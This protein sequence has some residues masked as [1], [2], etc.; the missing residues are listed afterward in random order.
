MYMWL[1]HLMLAPF[2]LSTI[3]TNTTLD[4]PHELG[5]LIQGLPKVA[6]DVLLTAFPSISSP[7]K[8][9][10][11][12]V[13]LVVRL[14]LR[15]D[16]QL[17]KLPQK[18]A[19]HAVQFLLSAND[20]GQTVYHDLGHL[21]LLYALVNLGSDSEVSLFL[22]PV[23]EA[24]ST[25]VT[26]SQTN[27]AATR[28][29]APARKMLIKVMRAC[30]THAIRLAEGSHGPNPDSINSMLEDSVQYYLDALGDKD[31]PVRM[32]A[33]KALSIIAL[34]LDVSM[35]AEIVEAVLG[36]LSENVLVE[37]LQTGQIMAKTDMSTA[38]GR[39]MKRNV[40]AVDALKWHGLMLTL[41]HLLFRR[42]RPPHQL[43]DILEAL[44]LGLE[45]EQ[46]SNVGTS[47]GIGVRDAACFG[48]WALARKYSTHELIAV[49]AD[50]ISGAF[51][52]SN[53]TPQS[54]LQVIATRLVLSSCLDPS[55]N[56]RRGSS[57]ALQE[58]I[59]RHPDTIV[60][61]IPVVQ[62]VDYLAVARRSRAVTEVAVMVSAL[63]PCYHDALLNA[64]LDWR[65]ARAADADSRRWAAIAVEEL[66]GSAPATKRAE[67]LEK[68]LSDL[69]ALKV[70]N[71][72]VTAA[73]RHGLLLCAA[74][75]LTS[76][77][78][79]EHAPSGKVLAVIHDVDVEALSGNLTGRTT[80]DLELVMEGL[81][82]F[83]AAMVIAIADTDKDFEPLSMRFWNILNHSLLASEK[84]S[85]VQACIAAAE[86]LFNRL[87]YKQKQTLTLQ[88]LDEKKQKPSETLCHGRL[89]MLATLHPHMSFDAKLQERVEELLTGTVSGS[90]RIEI[91]VNAMQSLRV[92]LS[93]SPE[94][95]LEIQSL[96][97]EAF[98][99]GLSDYT[100]DQRGD[101]GSLLRLKGIE[102]VDAYQKLVRMRQ[103][104]DVVEDPLLPH[105]VRL[106]IERLSKVRHRAW[107]CLMESWG[108]V[109]DGVTLT[110]NFKYLVD[111]SS[112]AYF[113][114]VV[115]L[116]RVEK[117]QG[118]VLR[119]LSS[120][121]GGGTE[122]ICRACSVA[123]LGWIM[124]MEQGERDRTTRSITISVCKYLEGLKEGEDK[125]VVPGLTFTTFL[126]EQ[127]LLSNQV[128]EGSD[129][130]S[131][132]VWTSVSKLHVQNVSM[133]RLAALI[134][135]YAALVRTS[136]HRN[137]ALD[138]LT[139][140]LLHR[141]PKIRNAAA[142]ALYPM[143]P[144]DR[145]LIC[146]WSAPAASNKATV[147]ELRKGMQLVPAAKA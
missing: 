142:D 136:V 134:Q 118:Q 1:S 119:G 66:C 96:L 128:L 53:R 37:D 85:V 40:N 48:I 49:Q 91:K 58:L 68:T 15:K 125:D 106:A 138:K 52:H 140:Q 75:I 79:H 57:A 30:M 78:E 43:P 11:S 141:Y 29:S 61:G 108:N 38:D 46:R 23:H 51:A 117:L 18:L 36:S 130:G 132:A 99:A 31:S 73:N 34:R 144:L 124:V 44:L 80:T 71:L 135:F 116:L 67:M 14:A 9:R 21:S 107:R 111:L 100:N 17:L 115:S 55:G 82:K 7:S 2:E 147:L 121:I 42:S 39:R 94:R 86:K 41:G 62:I 63:D 131:V 81:G 89:S 95:C 145:L 13:L 69:Q 27:H 20:S 35:S 6:Q 70:T 114:Q 4:V 87:D 101:I 97:C 109:I 103:S 110:D 93:V 143:F 102:A 33:S 105:I 19:T 92:L 5:H 59:G 90:Q 16:M 26:S 56:I 133:E 45:F 120:S 139:R 28:D 50:D 84:E 137:P 64:L 127:N 54:V 24:A 60:E 12:A 76:I 104:S 98:I 146:D 126:L 129:N 10:E 72:G 65:G 113:I 123:L 47:I 74:A 3:S 8:E 77:S 83:I 88:W 25:L 122:D 22:Q 112:E 32:A